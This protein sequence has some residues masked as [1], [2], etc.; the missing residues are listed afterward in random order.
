MIA[1]SMKTV[2]KLNKPIT[3]PK[4]AVSQPNF[5][6]SAIT[7]KKVFDWL[8]ISYECGGVDTLGFL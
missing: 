1:Y 6:S 3:K 7:V 4:E 8:I 5:I 2:V